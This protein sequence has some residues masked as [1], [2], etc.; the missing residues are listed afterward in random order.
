MIK[1]DGVEERFKRNTVRRM[2]V[3]NLTDHKMNPESV[4]KAGKDWDYS[5]DA[6]LGMKHGQDEIDTTDNTEKEFRHKGEIAD[7]LDYKAIYLDKKGLG[8]HITG[9][10]K[11]SLGPIGMIWITY[12]NGIKTR[13]KASERLPQI[14][15]YPF[16]DGSYLVIIQPFSKTGGEKIDHDR[17]SNAEHRIVICN[18]YWYTGASLVYDAD[19]IVS[20]SESI[21]PLQVLHNGSKNPWATDVDNTMLHGEYSIEPGSKHRDASAFL[22]RGAIPLAGHIDLNLW[23][24]KLRGPAGTFCWDGVWIN[25]DDNIMKVL[26]DGN[27]VNAQTLCFGKGYAVLLGNGRG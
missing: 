18:T 13:V 21:R 12:D 17:G 10:F 25:Y 23:K 19:V 1:P 14:T 7:T 3:V 5:T 16:G 9:T 8:T 27:V 24:A 15:A 26:T 2:V 6:K 20:D 11:W 4:L 22:S